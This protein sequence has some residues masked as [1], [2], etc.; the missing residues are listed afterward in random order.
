M[1]L[2]PAQTARTAYE[3]LEPYHVVAYFNPAI[4]VAAAELG[5]D[6]HAFYV[7][8]RGAP[9]GECAAA[10][11]AATFYNF[12][13]ALIAVA[14]RNA[15]AVGLAEIDDA[16]YT[17]LD[18]QYRA[19]LGAIGPPVEEVARGLGRLVDELPLTGRPLAAAW[20]GTP[21]PD[22][23]SLALWRHISVLREWRGDNHIAELIRH[24]LDG[25]D[26]G[27]F[28]EAGLPDDAGI[29]RRT[30]GRRFYQGTRGWSD[31]E[32]DASVDRLAARGLVERVDGDAGHRLTADG[33]QLYRE[34]E[35][36]TDVVTGA[37]FA[38]PDAAALIERARPVVKAVIDAGILPGT[39]RR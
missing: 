14:W 3:T 39:K 32:W 1:T 8:A 4:H 10:V 7:G 2:T 26:A 19:I 13:P 34:I 21:V 38:G 35:A 15:V 24:G 29:R 33:L 27:T 9:L 5:L 20:A 25:I 17:M 31:G 23:P 6:G 16:R 37:A 30:L 28:H 36:G 11:V 12:S 22:S 18:E